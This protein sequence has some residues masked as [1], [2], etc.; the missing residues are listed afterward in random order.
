M[1][2]GRDFDN[3]DS[4]KAESVVILSRTLADRIRAAGHSP[5]GYPV[6]LGSG[7]ARWSKVVGVCADARYRSVT[8]TGVD[9][10]VPYLQ[11]S[12]PTNY[13]VIRG[14]QSA[15]NLADM[16][17]RELAQIDSAQAV[18]GVATIGELI[19]ANTAR[20][21]FNMILLSWFALCA[22]ILAAAGVYS[23]V[24]ETMAARNREIAI[25]TAL[26]AGRIRLA[27]DMVTYAMRFVLIGELFGAFIL[28]SLGKLISELLYGVTARDPFVPGSAAALMFV[29]S[30][31]A[32]FW[33]AWSAAGADPKTSMGAG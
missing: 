8:Q 17:R 33:P 5:L 10:F 7:S 29:V 24:A 18:A 13:V 4:G 27:W 23:M 9:I 19:D 22:A 15:Q 12:P 11:A 6:R 25:R 3:R 31:I 1:L 32:A 26:G 14:T 16:V 2:E 30:A 20:H 21:R 28:F